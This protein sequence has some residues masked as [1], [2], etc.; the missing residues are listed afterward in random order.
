MLAKQGS[1]KWAVV[2]H[3]TFGVGCCTNASRPGW[4]PLEG[5]NQYAIPTGTFGVDDFPPG[6]Y[7]KPISK[8]ALLVLKTYPPKANGRLFWHFRDRERL[9]G[10][11][12]LIHTLGEG[13]SVFRVG[14]HFQTSNVCGLRPV[15]PWG[16]CMG[17]QRARPAQKECLKTAWSH[18]MQCVNFNLPSDQGL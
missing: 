6:N 10:C 2:V 3:E 11:E 5:T 17:Q 8:P 9:K 18:G 1:F 4:G 7:G 13:P 14:S 16:L 12:R 15:G